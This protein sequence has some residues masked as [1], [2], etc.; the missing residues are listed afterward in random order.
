MSDMLDDT[1]DVVEI[2][3]SLL[4]QMQR[5]RPHADDDVTTPDSE[6]GWRSKKRKTSSPSAAD[7]VDDVIEEVFGGRPTASVVPPFERCAEYWALKDLVRAA[8]FEPSRRG[9]FAPIG[10]VGVARLKVCSKKTIPADPL[11]NVKDHAE[12]FQLVARRMGTV[13]D[14]SVRKDVQRVDKGDTGHRQGCVPRNRH[15]PKQLDRDPDRGAGVGIQ[16]SGQGFC[17]AS[18]FFLFR[19]DDRQTWLLMS[20][21]ATFFAHIPKFTACVYA[22]TSSKVRRTEHFSLLMIMLRVKIFTTVS[23]I[24]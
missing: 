19:I 9:T 24:R 6:V 2:D 7:A 16:R 20:A 1:D 14:Q 10:F 17:E 3:R 8:R 4:P 23:W 11:T 13:S 5:K 15:G 12:R 18:S 22:G 21:M